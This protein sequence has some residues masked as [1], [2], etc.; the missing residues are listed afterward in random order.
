VFKLWE[1]TQEKR[2]KQMI[3][4]DSSRMGAIRAKLESLGIPIEEIAFM[5]DPQLD[6]D[7]QKL[8]EDNVRVL[9]SSTPRANSIP[10]FRIDSLSVIHTLE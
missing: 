5:Q 1:K 2:S 4:T 10:P 9:I 8:I 6:Q 3:F 7:R